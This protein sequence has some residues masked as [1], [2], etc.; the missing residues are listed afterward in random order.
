MGDFVSEKDVEQI[1][2]HYEAY[3]ADGTF[4]ETDNRGAPRSGVR[5][6]TTFRE[7]STHYVE[8]LLRYIEMEQFLRMQ[9]TDDEHRLAW[10]EADTS[11]LEDVRGHINNEGGTIRAAIDALMSLQGSALP[12]GT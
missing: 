3:T 6:A 11:R 12:S 1:R 5:D 2:A 8:R 9:G 7:V 10:L 4:L